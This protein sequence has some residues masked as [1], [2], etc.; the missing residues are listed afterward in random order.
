MAR[1]AEFRFRLYSNT[2]PMASRTK[3][4]HPSPNPTLA[5]KNPKT[6]RGGGGGQEILLL[7][8]ILYQYVIDTLLKL[9][10]KS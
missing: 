1:F 3:H 10:P 2:S 8:D 5:P 7:N 4:S 6:L 9:N